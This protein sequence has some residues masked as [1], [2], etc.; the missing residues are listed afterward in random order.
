MALYLASLFITGLWQKGDPNLAMIT[1]ALCVV[2]SAQALLSAY[3]LKEEGFLVRALYALASILFVMFIAFNWDGFT[4][5]LLWLLTA[6][7]VF[8]IG[9]RLRSV[10]IRMAAILLIGVTLAK[11]LVLDSIV[12]TTVQKVIAYLVLGILLL[13]VS[14]FYQK[15][16]QQ[17][18]SDKE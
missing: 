6:V 17:L 14:F 15:F 2:V 9:F 7:V 4:V 8:M 13:V 3:Y 18:F 1:L 16:R 11:L 5:T 12:F 10:G